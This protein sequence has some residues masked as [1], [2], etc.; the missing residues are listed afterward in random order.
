MVKDIIFFN[1]LDG[2]YY[3]IGE[4]HPDDKGEIQLPNIERLEDLQEAIHLLMI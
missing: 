4:Y 3:F 2:G 1:L